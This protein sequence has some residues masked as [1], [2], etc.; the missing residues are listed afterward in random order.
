MANPIQ[1]LRR[2]SA[3]YRQ[4]SRDD[5]RR[6]W[7]EGLLNHALL[8]LTLLFIVVT[9]LINRHFLQLR[10]VVN[11]ITL[12]ASLLPLALGMGCCMALAGLDLSAGRVVGLSAAV[13]A[14]LLQSADWPNRLLSFLPDLPAG[15]SLVLALAAAAA[16]GVLVGL[17]NGFFVAQFRLPPV[18]VTLATQLIVYG[19]ILMFF[20]VGG[21]NGQP[22]SGLSPVYAQAVTGAMVTLTEDVFLPWYVLYAVLLAAVLWVIWNKTAFGKGLLATG[23]NPRAAYVSGVSVFRTTVLAHGLAGLFYGLAGF[24]EAARI[25]AVSQITGQSYEVD[26]IVAC[27]IG[28]VSIGGGTGRVGGIVL[29]VLVL[30]IVFVG[31]NMLGIDANLQYVV[32]GLV[33]LAACSL[34]MRRYLARK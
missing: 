31:L 32:K 30:R 4:M 15:L 20:M 12:S 2:T 33:I 25:G 24:L 17:V 26:A 28:G 16:V 7:T 19:L 9:A 14:A 29:G 18:I 34:D 13:S 6:F 3:A 27:V 11:L 10:S 5:R 21:N 8:L 23:S 22:I 1:S